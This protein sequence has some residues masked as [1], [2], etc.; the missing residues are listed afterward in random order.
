MPESRAPRGGGDS[1]GAKGIFT[2]RIGPLPMWA[3][4]LII[5]G[6]IIAWSWYQ[7]RKAASSSSTG[8]NSTSASDVPQFVNQ[9]FVSTTAPTQ[10]PPG[11]T[12]KTGKTG[13][14]GKSNLTRTWESLGGSTYPEV[15]QRLLGNAD[16]ADL[17]PADK[18]TQTWVEKTYAKNHNAKM[19]K[20]LK[21]TYT[22]GDVTS[23][24]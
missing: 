2:N 17:H 14:T 19:P 21:F 7:N 10:G 13:G 12:G 3:W 11:P 18:R 1:G 9:T 6:I 20:G 16:V 15:A 24:K 5:V 23:K 8:D 4:L 22:E